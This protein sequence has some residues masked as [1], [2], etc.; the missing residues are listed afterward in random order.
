MELFHILVLRLASL[1]SRL[2]AATV[3]IVSFIP[4]I[5]T[6]TAYNKHSHIKQVSATYALSHVKHMLLLAR[7]AKARSI[8]HTEAHGTFCVL[9]NN[10]ARSCLVNLF[11][12]DQVTEVF[13]L[14]PLQLIAIAVHFDV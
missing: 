4:I 14:I 3:T 8:G 1:V 13:E 6:S 5:N 12:I 9:M 11:S 7:P 2:G 10:S